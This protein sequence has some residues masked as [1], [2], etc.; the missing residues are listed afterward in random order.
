MT[1]TATRDS[2]EETI[3]NQE[4][5]TIR[6]QVD[7]LVR[8]HD[9]ELGKILQDMRDSPNTQ[10]NL[11]VVLEIICRQSD[12]LHLLDRQIRLL[13]DAVQPETEFVWQ[14]GAD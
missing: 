12:W 2:I 13:Q 3:I 4:I 5:V 14:V 6:Q 8:E 11:F 7:E 1:Y 9:E 10:I